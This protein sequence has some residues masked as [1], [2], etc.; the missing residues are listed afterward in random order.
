MRSYKRLILEWYQAFPKFKLLWTY[1]VK[2]AIHWCV[3]SL[4]RS[5]SLWP[6]ERDSLLHRKLETKSVS[7][8]VTSKPAA[9]KSHLRTGKVNGYHAVHEEEL[10]VL[11][12]KS[13][14]WY[15]QISSSDP[16]LPKVLLKKEINGRNS[17]GNMT[18]PTQLILK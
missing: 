7:P 14:V 8:D 15:R 16:F 1:Q 4:Q 9:W 18:K 13:R 17:T 10:W 3:C 2:S 11:T 12:E 5:M 6:C